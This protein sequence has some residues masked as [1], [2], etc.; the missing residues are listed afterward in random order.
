[1]RLRELVSAAITIALAASGCVSAEDHGT[2]GTTAVGSSQLS[3]PSHTGSSPGDSVTSTSFSVLS[4][5]IS[6]EEFPFS[7]G[8]LIWRPSDEVQ[9]GLVGTER[10]GPAGFGVLQGGSIVLADSI[11]ARLV[12]FDPVSMLETFLGGLENQVAFAIGEGDIAYYLAGDGTVARSVE[13]VGPDSD[14][15]DFVNLPIG[16]FQ[17]IGNGR[18]FPWYESRPAGANEEV[19]PLGGHTAEIIPTFVGDSVNIEGESFGWSLSLDSS[20]LPPFRLETTN[21]DAVVGLFLTVDAAGQPDG[22]LALRLTRSGA[23]G[24]RLELPVL[25]YDVF[26]E[27]DWDIHGDAVYWLSGGSSVVGIYRV[28]VPS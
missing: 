15:V 26:G 3:S 4:L 19:D 12:V 28:T 20:V 27:G 25:P 2:E 22:V 17:L 23:S 18:A 13:A 10:N 21:G 1:M 6:A 11:R 8:E 9:A 5:A 7:A 24:V 16:S 14:R